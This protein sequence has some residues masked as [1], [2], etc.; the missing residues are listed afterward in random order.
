MSGVIHAYDVVLYDDADRLGRI[1][2]E[3]SKRLEGEKIL[4]QWN[5][6][7]ERSLVQLCRKD[8]NELVRKRSGQ[9]KRIEK[10]DRGYVQWIMFSVCW[11]K[12]NSYQDF[13]FRLREKIFSSEI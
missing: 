13:L 9:C 6:I 1:I 10:C 5:K 4:I 7:S 8:S 12:E 2:S 3:R 11:S